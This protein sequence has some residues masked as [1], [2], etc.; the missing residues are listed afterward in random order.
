MST[1]GGI[2]AIKSVIRYAG[3][4]GPV[5]LYKTL[6]SN[7]A[8]KACGFGTGGQNGGFWNEAGRGIEICNKNIQAHVSDTRPAI[9]DSVFEKNSIE[10]LSNLSGK[11]LEDLGRL[12]TPLYKSQTDTHY[13]SISMEE[14]IEK[15]VAKMQSISPDESFFYASGRSSNE[16]AFTLQLF[17]RL[18][19]TNNV[20]N[21]SYYCHQASGVGLN[22]VLGTGTATIQYQDL[23]LADTIVVLGANP[24]SNHPRFVKTLIQ[25]RRR[26]GN[27][28]VINPVKEPGL[29]KFASPSDWKSMI[30]GGESVASDYVQP[31]IG[32]D[33]A[34]LTGIAKGVFELGLEDTEFLRQHCDK[35][36]YYKESVSNSDWSEIEIQSGISKEKI[37]SL[38]NIIGSSEHTVYAWGMGMTH[39]RHGTEN[40]ETIASLALIKG[41]VGKQ[42]AG[43]L[44]LRGHSNIQGVGSM[45]FTPALKEKIFSNLESMLEV[46]LP[47][48]PGLN[49]METMIA[50]D[51]NKMKFALML[52]GNL[53]ASNPDSTFANRALS[54]V[55]FKVFLTNSVNSGHV[56]GI[57]AKDNA[58]CESII[59]PIRARDEEKQGTTQESMFNYVRLSD[60]GINR[61]D[62]L[63]SEVEIIS[64]IA[65]RVIHKEQLDFSQFKNHQHIREAIGKIIP[66][67]QAMEGINDAKQE[68]QIEGRTFYEPTFNTPNKKAKLCSHFKPKNENKTHDNHF[69]LMSVRSEGQFNSI[70][71]DEKDVYRDQA[72]RWIVMMHPDDMERLGL[73]Q[74]QVVTLSTETGTMENLKVRPFDIKEGNLMCYYPEVNVLV[75]AKVDARS[76]TPGF[77]SVDVKL[78]V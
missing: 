64:E 29:V 78:T 49:T 3:K 47:K 69:K 6:S 31:N 20:N 27:V 41:M 13:Q 21:C 55:P 15:I 38:S 24:A 30:K 51:E 52:G 23:A 56:N 7:N 68:F 4:I 40:I 62:H 60:G 17:A 1:G 25:C 5:N 2:K 39:H 75:P 37:L 66:G 71:Y 14:A 63:W 33:I 36:E 11:Q 32:G 16:A 28:I 19:G 72:E 45:G 34:L 58:D 8:C 48:M 57:L 74:N 26:G 77:K 42:G 46:D 67:F 70:V 18:F 44:P 54:K 22:E 10:A 65:S 9:P 61:Y 43:L 35:V 12:A 50:A 59:L 76:G 73:T 53:F